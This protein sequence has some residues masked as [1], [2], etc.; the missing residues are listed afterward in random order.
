MERYTWEPGGWQVTVEEVSA[1]VYEIIAARD[2]AGEIRL[3]TTD[4]DAGLERCREEATKRAQAASAE[5]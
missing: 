1:G 2:T 4:P 3:T 5:S